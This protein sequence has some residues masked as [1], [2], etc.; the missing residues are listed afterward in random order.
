MDNVHLTGPP[1]SGNVKAIALLIIDM[2]QDFVLPQS[3]FCVAGAEAS[4]PVLRKLLDHAR[5]RRWVIYHVI[6]RHK[7]DGSDAELFR[8]HLYRSGQGLC[9]DGS[10]G[11]AIVPELAPM[12]GECCLSKTRFSAFYNTPLERELGAKGV[13]TVV[14]GGTQYPNCV[15]GTAM[16]A[17]YRDFQV[18]V[19][20]DACSAASHEV[21]DANIRDMRNM[22]ILCSPLSHLDTALALAAPPGHVL[23]SSGGF[24]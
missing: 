22:G 9:V 11:S 13:H 16:D 19:V 14:L 1:S 3:P 23:D 18:I 21:V 17:L 12:P 6:R 7:A 2:Q 4:I 15:R 8:R 5:K 20:T 24:A 10:P